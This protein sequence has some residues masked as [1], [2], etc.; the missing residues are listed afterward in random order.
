MPG[1]NKLQR[2][3]EMKEFSNV[4]EPKLDE[5]KAGEEEVKFKPHRIKGEWKRS[6]FKNENP[7]VL[8][9]GCG[10]GEYAVGMGRKFKNKNFLGV[11]I[12]GARMWRGAKTA[13]DEGLENVG[14]L[15]TRIEF[16]DLFFDNNEVDEIWIT[17]P[18]P[19]LK[20]SR[21]RKRLT[22]PLFTERYKKFIKEGGLVHLK[23]DNTPLYEFT[24]DEIRKNGFQLLFETNDLYK[25]GMEHFDEEVREILT[26][27]THYEK[28]F[29]E[30]GFKIK[31]IKFQIK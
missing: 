30:K 19:Q 16:I 14:F 13:I 26:I 8:E 22:G 9:L 17:F 27:K 29:S 12:K 24:L 7:L 11:D 3:A 23:T 2:F 31:Y 15:R 4:L 6:F 20:R 28:I 1:K 5:I 10:K 18:D 25:K 21:E